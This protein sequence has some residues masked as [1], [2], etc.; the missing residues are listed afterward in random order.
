MAV[1]QG[2]SILRFRIIPILLV[3]RTAIWVKVRINN[4]AVIVFSLEAVRVNILLVND[5]RS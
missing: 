5:V 2:A 4:G 3:D 1:I